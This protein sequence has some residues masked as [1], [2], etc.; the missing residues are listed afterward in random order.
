MD[1]IVSPME[2]RTALGLDVDMTRDLTL[3][4]GGTGKTGSR[5]ARRLREH[6]RSVRIASRHGDPGFD[7]NDSGTWPGVLAAVTAAYVVYYPDLGFPGAADT[8]G[9][10]ARAA[11]GHGV[12]R[13]VL[14]SGRGEDEALVSEDAVR[15]AAPDVTVIRAS[16]FMQNFSEHF[17]LEPVLDGV[18]AL[19]AGDVAEPFVD[20]DDV[21]DV[22]VAAIT[23]GRHAGTVYELTG[24]R[25][26]TFADVAAVLTVVTGREITYVP[27]TPEEYAA[28]AAAHGVPPEEIEPLTEL[29]T[30][31]LDGRN[32][33]TT[34]DVERV[35]GRAPR[36]FTEYARATAA[37][38]AWDV[39][40]PEAVGC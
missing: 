2:R 15:A 8:V 5:V 36:D 26:L 31:V 29:F 12:D 13:L 39:H 10:F 9:A 18:I 16:W 32:A 6:G 37:A 34:D 4:L 17:L 23:D 1:S 27:V 21:A 7:W 40:P 35:L 38:G 33:H 30:R 22:A 14:L 20:V 24:P 3:V 28:A 19:P 11:V 25:L